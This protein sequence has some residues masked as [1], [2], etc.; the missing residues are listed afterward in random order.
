MKI[1][2]LLEAIEAQLANYEIDLMELP[3]D[4][5]DYVRKKMAIL[6][7]EKA[8]QCCEE[9]TLEIAFLWYKWKI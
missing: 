6:L 4:E 1:A 8:E 3:E 2:E 9:K 7:V 5:Y